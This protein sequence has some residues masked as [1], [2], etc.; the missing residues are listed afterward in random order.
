MAAI[1][2]SAVPEHTGITNGDAPAR[3]TLKIVY[4]PAGPDDID[5]EDSEDEGDYLKA[6][7]E[8]RESDGLSDEDDD[9]E[10][11]DDDEEK[12][13]G[14]SDP[15]KSKKARKEAALQEMIKALAENSDADSEDEM[16]VD[17]LVGMNGK[18][19]DPKMKK[20]KG[21]ATDLDEDEASAD[22][23]DD[24]DFTESMREL[25]VCTLDPH[26]VGMLHR[27]LLVLW[28]GLRIVL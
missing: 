12:N 15:S 4:N 22:E 20:G 19:K 3:A 7:L 27:S 6:L 25:I 26:K 28:R 10:S 9:D 17:G 13:G 5:S 23:D 18:G 1:D 11:S 16:D 21:K 8:G 14:P 24:E 2:P